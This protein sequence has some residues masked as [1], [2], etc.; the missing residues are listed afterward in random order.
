MIRVSAVVHA[1]G[2]AD[3]VIVVAAV[4]SPGVVRAVDRTGSVQIVQH[5][6]ES[7]AMDARARQKDAV[8]R[9]RGRR[10]VFQGRRGNG[11]RI[12][13]VAAGVV[14]SVMVV[15]VVVAVVLRR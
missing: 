7:V 9:G 8:E 14:I 5:G 6:V 13:V 2:A 1:R 3:V 11:G 12:V 4:N 15:P 10:R